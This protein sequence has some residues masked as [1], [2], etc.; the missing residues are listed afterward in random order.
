MQPIAE[1]VGGAVENLDNALFA[2][3]KRPRS[4]T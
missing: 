3:I 4:D 2:P 1:S